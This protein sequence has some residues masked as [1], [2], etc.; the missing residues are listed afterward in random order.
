MADPPPAQPPLKFGFKLSG[1]GTSKKPAGSLAGTKRPFAAPEDDEAPQHQEITHFNQSAGGAYNQTSK[2]D[3]T[4]RIIKPSKKHV[5]QL[6][7]E[8]TDSPPPGSYTPTPEAHK[9]LIKETEKQYG[10]I[11]PD[12]STDPSIGKSANQ[13]S[14]DPS[15]GG[16]ASHARAISRPVSDE[17]AFNRDVA[18]AESPPKETD[19]DDC[20]VEGFGAAFLRGLGWQ[21]GE[22]IGRRQ[23][24]PA[25]QFKPHERRPARLGV[26]G[27]PMDATDVEFGAWGKQAKDKTHLPVVA[28]NVN[29]GETMTNMEYEKR[30]TKE[31]AGDD[32]YVSQISSESDQAGNTNPGLERPE[33]DEG[34]HD[35]SEASRD[36][37]IILIASYELSPLPSAPDWYRE[38]DTYRPYYGPPKQ[39]S[40]DITPRNHSDTNPKHYRP[41]N[42]YRPDYTLAPRL[43]SPSPYHYESIPDGGRFI[44]PSLE[45]DVPNKPHAAIGRD[46]YLP[47]YDLRDPEQ[48][49][50][51]ESIERL[52]VGLRDDPLVHLQAQLDSAK[53]ERKEIKL[54]YKHAEK[55]LLDAY[56]K[57]K[58][59]K[60]QQNAPERALNASQEAELEDGEIRETEGEELEDEETKRAQALADEAKEQ[61]KQSNTRVRDLGRMVADERLARG[62]PTYKKQRIDRWTPSPEPLPAKKK[63]NKK[64]KHHRGPWNEMRFRSAGMAY[65]LGQ[66]DPRQ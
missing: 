55:R 13:T 29:T 51:H 57:R 61:V 53:S 46:P 44:S 47:H 59:K 32:R 23:D 5:S 36:S 39:E 45:R 66:E 25:Q 19:Y 41:Y 21:D 37:D 17:D 28:R 2:P 9:A 65:W 6:R 27:K 8:S 58:Q 14:S 7:D 22:A 30:V 63:K 48:R 10:L 42:S 54:H 24:K 31:R 43:R 4:L 16:A 33:T 20:P 15:N 18:E 49:A 60:R 52:D 1:A 34:L 35:G 11:L 3:Q 50:R 56:A 38:R 64:S 26:G 62:M 12:T 40:R